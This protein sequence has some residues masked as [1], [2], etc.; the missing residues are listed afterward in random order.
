MDLCLKSV[1]I[2]HVFSMGLMPVIHIGMLCIIFFDSLIM[3]YKQDK[4]MGTTGLK[5]PHNRTPLREIQVSERE[6]ANGVHA[7]SNNF[8]KLQAASKEKFLVPMSKTNDGNTKETTMTTNLQNDD[9]KGQHIDDEG[10]YI[11]ENESLE[12]KAEKLV[13]GGKSVLSAFK[14]LE[15]YRSN[16]HHHKPRHYP[17]P[18]NQ[19]QLDLSI[20]A[21]TRAP[22]ARHVVACPCS[23]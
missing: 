6:N 13:K 23:V 4:E 1:S 16:H 7:R 12:L 3:F 18:Y 8:L 19:N 20:E 5:K 17:R 2:L 11:H 15:E 10:K 9:S 22:L 21:Q 14:A